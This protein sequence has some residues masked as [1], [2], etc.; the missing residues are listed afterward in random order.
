MK[1]PQYAT[2]Y[3]ER[4]LPQGAPTSPALANLAAYVLD[5]RL[6]GLAKKFGVAYTRYADDLT[7]SGDEHIIVG[8]SMNWL[9]RYMR[10]IVRDE[11]FTW[12]NHKKK[13]IRSG[14]RQIVTGLTVNEKP[15]VSRKEFDRL[16]AIL[17]N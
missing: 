4:H 14:H 7:F 17:S 8:K 11:K 12:N 10:G 9:I 3:A 15:N 16:K 2:F 13:I 5:V 6:S 1:I